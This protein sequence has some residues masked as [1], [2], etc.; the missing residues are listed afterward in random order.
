MFHI[1][2]VGQGKKCTLCCCNKAKNAVSVAPRHFAGTEGFFFYFSETWNDKKKS[3]W[4]FER[5]KLPFNIEIFLPF[6]YRLTIR[7]SIF[8]WFLTFS[9]LKYKIWQ[10]GFFSSFQWIFAG[11]TGSKNPVHQTRNLKLWTSKIKCR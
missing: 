8:T 6:G 5:K 2:Q 1:K 7:L 10:T 9:S 4:K 3:I 11:Y